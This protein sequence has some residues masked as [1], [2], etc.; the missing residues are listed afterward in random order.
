MYE[1]EEAIFYYVTVYNEDYM[2]Q[3]MPKGTEE[4]IRRGMYK[5]SSKDV[6]KAA[7]RVQLFGS[8]PILRHVLEAQATLAEKYNIASDV[9]SVTSYKELR[10]DAL[11]VERWNLLHPTEKPKVSYIEKQLA[12]A[13]GPFVASSDYMRLVSEQIRPWVPGNYVVLGTDGFGRSET[14]PDLRRHFEVDANHVA[15]AALSALVRDGKL[16]RK[17][18]K[19]ATKDLQIDPEKLNP[20]HA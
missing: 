14:R 2:M 9:W 10:R 11:D 5:V 13:E 3:E 17:V 19:Q 12:G 16:D 8:G 6:A 4:G 20:M 1:D 18:I 7:A 15:F